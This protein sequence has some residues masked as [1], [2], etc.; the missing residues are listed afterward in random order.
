MAA[1]RPDSVIIVGGG[2][3]GLTAAYELCRAGVHAV[4]L[5]KNDKVGG[6]ART[7]SYRGFHFDIGGHRFFTKGDAVSRM[8]REV[9]GD[10]FLRRPR[11]S[12]IYYRGRFFPYPLKPWNSLAGL[13]AWQSL[14]V[15]LSY[16]RWQVAPYEREDT[17]E[18]WVTNRF[19]RRLFMIFFKSYTEKVWGIPCTE[20]QAEWAAQRIKDLSLKSAILTMFFSQRNVIKTLIEEFEYPRLGPG[21]MWNAVRERIVEA[22]GVVELESDVTQIRRGGNRIVDVVG[23]GSNGGTPRSASHFI[24]T[25]PITEL[26]ARI[27]PPPPDEVVQA[28]RTLR[29]RDFLTV[30]VIVDKPDLFPDNWIYVHDPNVRVARIQNFKNW[31]SAMVPDG[32]KSSLGLEYFCNQGD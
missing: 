18:E 16:F 27:D 23:G 30:C 9:L 10:E 1:A 21:M 12:R 7:E 5:E 20:L 3:A 4:V 19:G 26:V 31:S 8:W 15:A 22:G 14:L 24:S 11:L 32:A 6:L 25:M 2:P 13:V 28:A 29:H 17:F